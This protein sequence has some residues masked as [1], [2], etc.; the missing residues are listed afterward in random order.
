MVATS[1]VSGPA[2]MEGGGGYNRRSSVQAAGLALA[3]PLFEQAARTVSLA[4]APEAI[5]IA[6]YGSSEG[7]NSLAPCRQQSTL[8]EPGLGGI[9]QSRSYTRTWSGTISTRY[10]GPWPTIQTV[11]FVTNRRPLHRP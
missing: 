6:D 3:V 4:N 7:H 8:S 9:G 1:S 10:S 2:P 5:V 11:I